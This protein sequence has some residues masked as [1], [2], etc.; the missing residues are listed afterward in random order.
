MQNYLYL[1]LIP[2]ALIISQL[3]PEKFG[4]YIATGSKRQI[5]GPAVFFEVDPSA[6]LSAFRMD[7]ARARCKP[8]ADGSP[9]R[10]IYISV[11]N[12]LPQVPLEALRRAYLTTPAGLSLALDPADWQAAPGDNFFLYQE[13]GPV[14][15]RVATRLEPR[16][17]CQL[18]ANPE[19]MVSVPR[20]A[21]IDL[22]LG[23]LARDA[24]ALLDGNVPYQ[25]IDHLRECLRA[26]QEN[27]ERMTKI[28]NRGLR[29][30]ILFSFIRSGV[31]VGDATGLR[32]FPMPSEDRLE[33]EHNLWWHS[34]QALRGY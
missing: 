30:D 5:E 27:P 4:S 14:Y 8:H 21:F 6:D 3:P 28:V 26:L 29:P 23:V 1:S 16:A 7:E 31:F 13:L 9:R 15:P 34:A 32:F 18:V 10:S 24:D 19:K 20:I 12:V 11:W 2:E 17:F 22:K 25:H 33:S